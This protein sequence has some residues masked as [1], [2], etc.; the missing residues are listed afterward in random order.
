M[1]GVFARAGAGLVLGGL[2]QHHG[3]L[4][5]HVDLA[6]A[7]LLVLMVV[8]RLA[9][10][11]DR[12]VVVLQVL[13]VGYEVALAGDEGDGE[14]GA[15]RKGLLGCVENDCGWLAGRRGD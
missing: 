3:L 2:R 1:G 4:V 12:H 7:L 13:L 14:E 6:V 10:R 5:D 9:M 8:A 15:G 11:L